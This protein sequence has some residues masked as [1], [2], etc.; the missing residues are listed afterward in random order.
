MGCP[1]KTRKTPEVG[2]TQFG[3]KRSFPLL[4]SAKTEVWAASENRLIETKIFW[5]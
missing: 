5:Q 2:M 4:A 3:K 1:N